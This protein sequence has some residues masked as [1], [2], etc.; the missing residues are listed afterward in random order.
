[1]RQTRVTIRPR[2]PG[3]VPRLVELLAAQQADTGYPVHWPLP[4]PVEEF[5]VRRAEL[6][7]WVAGDGD[8]DS[9]LGHVALLD[10]GPGW[11]ADGWC[12]GTGLPASELAAVAVLFVDPAAVGRG[13][14]SALLARA[15]ERARA[16]ARTP[17]LDVVSESTP[18]VRLYERHGWR[19]VG[20]ARPPWLPIGRD[21]LL[22]MSLPAQPPGSPVPLPD[23]HRCR[24]YARGGRSGRPTG[25]EERGGA[26]AP[27]VPLAVIG[28]ILTFAVRAEPS[29]INLHVVGLILMV[30]GAGL[31]WHARRGTTHERVVTRVEGPVV[32]G[33]QLPSPITENHTVRE[34]IQ[35]RDH[36]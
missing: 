12:E 14:G 22:L 27:G 10:V 6:G 19:V 36:E 9:V 26:M 11:E 18:A 3:D 21:P 33:E 20:E 24:R 29:G 15:V 34:T 7:A 13:I 25:D 5:V 30:A 31:I 17:V 8:A 35:E 32:G 16:L 2:E 23:P 28:A 1:M 4:F